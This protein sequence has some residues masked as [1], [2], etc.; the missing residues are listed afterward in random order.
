M[1]KHIAIFSAVCSLFISGK[2]FS[3]ATNFEGITAGVNFSSVGG[4]TKISG[5]GNSVNYGQQSFVPSAEIGYNFAPASEIVLGITA[6]Y[7]FTDIKLGQEDY[8]NYKGQNRVSLNLKP[9]YIVAPNTM[10]YATVGFNSMKVKA[11]NSSSSNTKNLN[12]VGYG[13]GAAV[14]LT[15]NAFFKA[16]VQQIN[17]NSWNDGASLTPNL[18]IGTVGIGYKF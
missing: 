18:T 4:T 17:F 2:A 13:L 14:M 10:I 16:E 7:D 6:T 15:K 11:S 1:K 3:Q 8:L 12:G 5:S 9:G